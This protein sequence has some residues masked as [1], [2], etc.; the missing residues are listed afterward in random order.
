MMM[1]ELKS[2]SLWEN[3]KTCIHNNLITLSMVDGG[4]THEQPEDLDSEICMKLDSE[5][6]SSLIANTR[7][8]AGA[9]GGI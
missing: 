6:C 7:C 8:A 2:V 1:E 3:S 5:I 4:Y 9:S